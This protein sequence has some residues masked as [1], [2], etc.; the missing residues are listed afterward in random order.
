[1]TVLAIATIMAPGNI[2]R[3]TLD[4]AE[5]TSHLAFIGNYRDIKWQLIKD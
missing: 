3:S 2:A 5:N 1:M 4:V